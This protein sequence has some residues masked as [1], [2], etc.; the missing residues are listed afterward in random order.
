MS[1]SSGPQY[2]TLMPRLSQHFQHHDILQNVGLLS[3]RIIQ[4]KKATSLVEYRR[5]C[6]LLEQEQVDLQTF[7]H[8]DIRLDC[9]HLTRHFLRGLFFCILSVSGNLMSHGF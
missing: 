3:I 4:K 6:S 5:P 7:V 2:L 8:P 1:T 9:Q